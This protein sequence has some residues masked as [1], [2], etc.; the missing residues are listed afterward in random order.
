MEAVRVSRNAKSVLI[1]GNLIQGG[2]NHN[3]KVHGH[4]SGYKPTATIRNNVIKHPIR[5]DGVA[6]EDNGAVTI[7]GNTFDGAPEDNIDVKG[8]TVTITR[9]LFLSS[10]QGALV[11]QMYAQA[12]VENNRFASGR[13]IALSGPNGGD[14]GWTFRRNLVE[15]G[16]LR[17]RESFKPAIVEGNV[18]SEGTIKLG[19]P[20]GDYPR[21]ARFVGNSFDGTQL[22]D[23][24]TTQ[25]ETWI[26][27]DNFLS[28]VVG[29]WPASCG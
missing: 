5:E 20:D 1:T 23:R 28:N 27:S 6:T 4:G 25:G 11:V 24:T 14:P 2:G 29:D 21:D 8:G 7:D 17:L 12:T 10:S 13:I 9:N 18:M 26:C 22:I 3:I 16:E 19:F 15:G